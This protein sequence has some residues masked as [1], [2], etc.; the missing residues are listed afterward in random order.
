MKAQIHIDGKVI[1]TSNKIS[2]KNL[3]KKENE[4]K[5]KYGCL[6]MADIVRRGFNTF[7]A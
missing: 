5:H 7:R 1:F 4:L 3:E 6:K 2:N